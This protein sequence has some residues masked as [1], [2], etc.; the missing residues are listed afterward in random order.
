M[1]KESTVEA[2]PAKIRLNLEFPPPIHEQMQVVQQRSHAASL[3]EMLR[4]AVALYDLI[5]EHVMEGGEIILRNRKG[6]DKK[7]R[8]L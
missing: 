6:E 8:I 4:R 2:A 7:L 5:T 1:P 3:T